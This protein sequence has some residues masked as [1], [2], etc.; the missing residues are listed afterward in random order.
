MARVRRRDRRLAE[1]VVFTDRK[2]D[3]RRDQLQSEAVSGNEARVGETQ[4]ARKSRGVSGRKE[5][6]RI[7][8]SLS[9]RM[10]E[11][12]R[13]DEDGYCDRHEIRRER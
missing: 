11:Q 2:P 10:T 8:S 13:T 5:V 9:M 7:G 12:R 3:W 1:Q 6:V 4:I